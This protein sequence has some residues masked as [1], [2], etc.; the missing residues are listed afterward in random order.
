MFIVNSPS[1]V[2]VL[3]NSYGDPETV[4]PVLSFR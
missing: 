2:N 3:M 1:A 4:E